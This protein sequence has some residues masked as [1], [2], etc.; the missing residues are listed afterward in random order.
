MA[1]QLGSIHDLLACPYNPSHFV[2]ASKIQ[3]HLIKCRQQNPDKAKDILICAYNQAHHFNALEMSAHLSVCN[4]YMAHQ[5]HSMG[6]VCQEETYVYEPEVAESSICESED[7]VR[8]MDPYSEDENASDVSQPYVAPPKPALKYAPR[9]SLQVEV[10][11]REPNKVAPIVENRA[12][13][14]KPCSQEEIDN[15]TC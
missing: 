10:P 5:L 3:T 7:E 12:R 11:A 13:F 8:S 9:H 14:M 2:G 15:W 6:R 1:G 4:D